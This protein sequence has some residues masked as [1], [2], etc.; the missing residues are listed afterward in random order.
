M[1]PNCAGCLRSLS[2]VTR[3]IETRPPPFPDRFP[4]IASIFICISDNWSQICT[5]YPPSCK[6]FAT[7]EVA[8]I[9]NQSS[10]PSRVVVFSFQKNQPR[11]STA[12]YQAKKWAEIW[13][14]QVWQRPQAKE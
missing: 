11:K 1:V 9:R 5:T 14:N 12:R 3:R 2:T 6:I 8:E 7:G 10:P 4:H 13:G